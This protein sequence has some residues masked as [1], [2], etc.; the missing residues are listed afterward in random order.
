M[1]FPFRPLLDKVARIKVDIT[2]CF[3]VLSKFQAVLFYSKYSILW[4]IINVPDLSNT[5]QYETNVVTFILLNYGLRLN[6][7]DHK[8]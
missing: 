8:C 3:Q 7:V 5:T 2:I 4:R 6:F 1:L